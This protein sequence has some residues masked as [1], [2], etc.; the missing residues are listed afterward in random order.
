MFPTSDGASIIGEKQP[1]EYFNQ[2]DF[3]RY[4]NEQGLAFTQNKLAVYRLRGKLPKE[5]M[6]ISGKPYWTKETV[7]QYVMEKKKNQEEVQE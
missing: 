2:T 7:E 6:V 4:L 1:I 5:D 3:A